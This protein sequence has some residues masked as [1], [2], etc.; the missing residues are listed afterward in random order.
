MLQELPPSSL[1]PGIDLLRTPVQHCHREHDYHDDGN[2]GA[3]PLDFKL[4]FQKG[5]PD[6]KK[7]G[8]NEEEQCVQERACQIFSVPRP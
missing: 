5:L 8:N 7:Q 4:R 3:L 2:L 1:E 6:F